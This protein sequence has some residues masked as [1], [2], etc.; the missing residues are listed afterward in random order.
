MLA[1]YTIAG[2]YAAFQ[3][4]ETGSIE[5]GKAADLIVL[6]HNL[7]EVPPEKIHETKVVLTLLEGREVYRAP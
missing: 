3:E 4:R 1:A 6:D 7:F 5:V 2:A